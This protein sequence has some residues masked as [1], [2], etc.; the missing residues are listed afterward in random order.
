MASRAVKVRANL[1]FFFVASASRD[2]DKR[3]NGRFHLDL[4]SDEKCP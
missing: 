3:E 4:S 1:T 2:D